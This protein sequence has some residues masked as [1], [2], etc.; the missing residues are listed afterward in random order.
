MKYPD[1]GAA[2]KNETST[3]ER[4]SFDNRFTILAIVA[5]IPS[6]FLSP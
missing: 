2:I 4:N 5:P 1:T 3:S 6:G